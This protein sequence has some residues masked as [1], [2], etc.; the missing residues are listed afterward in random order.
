MLNCDVECLYFWW[1]YLVLCW[2]CVVGEVVYEVVLVLVYYVW[3]VFGVIVVGVGYQQQVEVFVG[4]YQ[5][6]YY[7]YGVGQWYV[8]VY[9]VVYQYQVV[10]EFGCVVF[11]GLVVVVVFVVFVDG[12]F[13]LVFFGLVVFVVVVVVVVV[14]GLGD[15]E[16]VGVVQYCVGGCIVVVGVVLDVYVVQVYLWIVFVQ[17]FQVDDLVWQ[18]VVVYVVIL[19]VME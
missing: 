16:E 12:E 13:V 4:I 8:V 3:C 15:F 11:V 9:C 6:M 1:G 7:Q 18:G 10:F 17:F 5:C 2:W 19:G 14:F